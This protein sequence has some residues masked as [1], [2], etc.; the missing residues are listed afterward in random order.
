MM[1]E[2]K[3]GTRQIA[4]AMVGMLML[5]AGLTLAGLPGESAAK[6]CQLQLSGPLAGD[7]AQR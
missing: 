7:C 2:R 6:V 1:Q 3:A 5:V 4:L